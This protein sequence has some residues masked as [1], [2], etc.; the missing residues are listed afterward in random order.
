MALWANCPRE[1]KLAAF[2]KIP[3]LLAALIQE[4]EEK[5][6][7]FETDTSTIDS[8]LAEVQAVKERRGPAKKG[9]RQ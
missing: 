8:L 7:Q 9:A 5:I 1:L 3:A 4:V 6:G 2:N